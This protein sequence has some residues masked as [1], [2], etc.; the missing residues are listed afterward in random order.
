VKR[1]GIWLV[2]LVLLGV[3]IALGLTGTAAGGA[4]AR[5][6]ASCRAHAGLPDRACTPG[7][8]D[9]RVK[10]GNIAT[11]ICRKGYTATVRPPSS[12]TTKLKKEQLA[13]YG[14]YA[15][16]KL[17]GYEEDHLV[18]LELG[19]DPRDPKNLWPEAYSPKPGARQK[20]TVEGY[21][22]RQVCDGKITLA[23][24]QRREERNW[25]NVYQ[26]LHP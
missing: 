5:E 4:G 2:L 14:Y 1:A 15:G 13:A 25:V 18:S 23:L 19:G 20:D 10:Q 17:S 11:T 9:P 24:A 16:T 21:L 22:H 6:A 26:Q 7:A 3:A 12:Y 8:R